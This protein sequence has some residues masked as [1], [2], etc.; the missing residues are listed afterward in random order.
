M[1]KPNVTTA[2]LA[3]LALSATV[4]AVQLTG[5]TVKQQL[6][7]SRAPLHSL[8]E[9]FAG[10]KQFF[11][12]VPRAGYLTDKNPENPVVIAQF[13]QAQYILAPTILELNNASLPVVICDFADPNVSVPK[14]KKFQLTPVSASNTGL[15]LAVRA[16][17]AEP[18]R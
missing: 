1:I 6:N 10:L 13:E 18:Q 11:A 15:I 5:R 12:G 14:L 17:L 4:S 7:P 9:Q 16:N 2:V 8:A 3:A